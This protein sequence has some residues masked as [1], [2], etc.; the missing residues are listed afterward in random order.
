MLLVGLVQR[1]YRDVVAWL[2]QWCMSRSLIR[3][4]CRLAG[5]A[6]VHKFMD[7]ALALWPKWQCASFANDGGCWQWD[8][9]SVGMILL[10]VPFMA[11]SGQAGLS[12]HGARGAVGVVFAAFCVVEGVFGSRTSVVQ[13]AVPL[14]LQR[15]AKRVWLGPDGLLP[16][17]RRF[18]PFSVLWTIAIRLICAEATTVLP[19]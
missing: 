6:A 1:C 14:D 19:F 7:F 10:V 12:W 8:A 9:G 2:A 3:T 5:E 17:W 16:Y 13:A 11:L 15:C 4:E 18:V